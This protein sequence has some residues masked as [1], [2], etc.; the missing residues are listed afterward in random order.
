M[1]INCPCCGERSLDEFVYYGDADV[2]RPDPEDSE[3]ITKFITYAYE[4]TNS[5]GFH[6][7]FWYHSMGCRSW[8]VAERDTRT[9][10]IYATCRAVDAG[11]PKSPATDGERD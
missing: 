5:S 11:A 6:R 3:A 4:R 2:R 9:H 1:R 8:I 10:E 7:E